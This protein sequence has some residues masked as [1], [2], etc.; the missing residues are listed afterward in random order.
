MNDNLKELMS[1]CKCSVSIEINPHR[2]YYESVSDELNKL[3]DSDIQEIDKEVIGEMILTDTF[4]RVQ[5]Y[6]D[7]PIG[8]YMAIHF[9]LDTAINIVLNGIKNNK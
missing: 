5:A 2:D 1:L 7:T 4:I 9:D 6:P 3:Q 8:F